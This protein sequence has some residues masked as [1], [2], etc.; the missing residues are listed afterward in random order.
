MVVEIRETTIADKPVVTNLLQFYLYDFSE[1]IG[2]GIP[3]DGRYTDEDMDGCWVDPLRHTFLVKVSGE[4]AGFA[5]VDDLR[6]GKDDE[7]VID[8]AEF[9][10]MRKFRKQGIGDYV[11][12]ALF[13][14]FKGRWRVRQLWQNAGALAFWRK[15][16]G[17]YTQG[18]YTDTTWAGR[19]SHGTVQFF[20]NS[21]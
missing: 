6:K 20:E 5:I 11:A 18:N 4:L 9:F 8:M 10:I 17:R 12:T 21:R 13:D 2:L 19:Y 1:M 15:V 16:I 3:N 14:R 7:H